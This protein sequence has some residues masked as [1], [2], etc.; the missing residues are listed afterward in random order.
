MATSLK[1]A[2]LITGCDSGFGFSLACHMSENH[3]EFLTV[4]TTFFPDSEGAA[5]LRSKSPNLKVLQ[6]DVT[7]PESI[8][9]LVKNVNDILGD[10][11]QLWTVV[12]NAATLVFADALWQTR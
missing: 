2:V 3:P 1:K 12:N 11:F 9:E 10:Q 5:I 4:A 7:K 8:E 6:L